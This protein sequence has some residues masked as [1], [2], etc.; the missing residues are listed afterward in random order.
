LSP[1]Y[2]ERLRQS[3][4]D[5]EAWREL[6][7]DVWPWVWADC[8]RLLR[9]PIGELLGPDDLAQEVFLDFAR[10]VH[11]GVGSLPTDET[12]LHETLA[13]I[14]RRIRNTHAHRAFRRRRLGGQ[15][16]QRHPPPEPPGPAAEAAYREQLL[17]LCERLSPLE[18]DVLRRQLDGYSQAETAAALHVSVKTVYRALRSIREILDASFP[19]EAEPGA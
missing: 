10:S 2:L 7:A 11:A 5:R 3:P 14:A 4:Q 8:Q 19:S 17:L 13:R 1:S 15:L 18:Q 16:P 6:A 12:A 9:V